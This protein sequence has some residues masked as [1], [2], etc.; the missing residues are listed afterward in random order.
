MSDF[1]NIH[2]KLLNDYPRAIIHMRMQFEAKRF[3][4]MFGSGLNKWFKLPNWPELVRKIA[5]DPKVKG[6]SILNRLS[7]SASLP[8]KTEI[9]FQHF[10]DLHASQLDPAHKNSRDFESNIHAEWLKICAK[11][12]Y[13]NASRDFK[14]KLAR[15][16]YLLKYIPIIQNTQM[17]ITYNFDDYIE[18]S[19]AE[20]RASG[21]TTKGYE[22]ITDPWTQ[23][24]RESGVVYHPHGVLAKELMETPVDKFVFSESSFTKKFLGALSGDLTALLNH[25]SK[26]TCLMIGLS[27]EDEMLRN[28]LVLSAQSNHGN[29]H[30]CVKFVA[31]NLD[32]AKREAIRQANFR[33]YN[34]ITLFL[35]D[36]EIAALGELINPSVFDDDQFVDRAQVIQKP[37]IYRFYITGALGAGK[38]T[39]IG[40]FRNLG[41]VDEWLEKRPGKLK[42]YW[43]KLS[44]KQRSDTDRWLRRQ[45]TLKNDNLR[46]KRWG[47]FVID[48]PPL[49]PLAFT[50]SIGRSAKAK[51]LYKAVCWD[52]SFEIAKGTVIL[53]QDDP[54]ELELRARLTDRSEYTAD[55]L[56]AMQRDLEKIY[57]GRG[58][59]IVETR[60][61]TMQ[62]TARKIAEIIHLEN[63]QEFDFTRRL[64]AYKEGRYGN[65]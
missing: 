50:Q 29:Y 7:K 34:L 22:T 47:I 3:C 10:R 63:Y 57:R 62:E 17:T 26:H 18:R 64:V 21:D 23:F 5:A 54:K 43:R 19:L 38:S 56:S 35:N 48:R 53:L 55:V 49:D 46:S 39:A 44:R 6:S 24:R 45:F 33:V 37:L 31:K 2:D 52:G 60:G 16:P 30:Y 27:L 40:K 58:L 61:R 1:K 4:L 11:N 32:A 13:G 9:L 28:L 12:L 15:H 20:R 25:L 51:K 8:Y 59:V 65:R 36:D 41:T 42:R 14:V